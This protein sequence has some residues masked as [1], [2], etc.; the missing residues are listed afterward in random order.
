MRVY[1]RVC[2]CERHVQTTLSDTLFSYQFAERRH[3]KHASRGLSNWD[4]ATS[5]FVGQ[6]PKARVRGEP[7]RGV[8]VF[9]L[10]DIVRLYFVIVAS[11]ERWG[12]QVLCRNPISHE[13][14]TKAQ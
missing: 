14:T 10:L 4:A 12:R 9:L 3:G 7:V 11:C 1:V 6:I 5:A 13:S 2:V 8:G